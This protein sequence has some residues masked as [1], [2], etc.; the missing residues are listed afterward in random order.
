LPTKR[1]QLHQGS[2]LLSHVPIIPYLLVSK[3]EVNVMGAVRQLCTFLY[4]STYSLM[5]DTHESKEILYGPLIKPSSLRALR[6]DSK[7]HHHA[8]SNH[9]QHWRDK[10]KKQQQ[11]QMRFPKNNSKVP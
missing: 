8:R 10:L 11:Q 3:T 4:A 5:E 2:F 1:I 9:T 7:G 6:K